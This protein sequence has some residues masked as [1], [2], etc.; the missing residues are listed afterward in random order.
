MNF[1]RL[2]SVGDSV[3]RGVSVS[4]SISNILPKRYILLIKVITHNS[5][6][7]SVMGN[8]GS[9]GDAMTVKDKDEFFKYMQ[10]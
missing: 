7:L 3:A 2:R 5:Q 9:H 1:Q 10:T 4:N 8:I 6:K